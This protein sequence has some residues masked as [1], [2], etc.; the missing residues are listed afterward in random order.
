MT[1]HIKEKVDGT[2]G[3]DQKKQVPADAL[4]GHV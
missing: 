2:S 4:L 3:H 1:A